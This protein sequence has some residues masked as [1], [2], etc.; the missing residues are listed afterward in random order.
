MYSVSNLQEF[1][2][3]HTSLPLSWSYHLNTFFFF[4]WLYMKAFSIYLE[5][6]FTYLCLTFVRGYNIVPNY[7]L[8]NIWLPVVRVWRK[9]ERQVNSCDFLCLIDDFHS[10][11]KAWKLFAY[12]RPFINLSKSKAGA[13]RESKWTFEIESNRLEMWKSQC[14]AK[15]LDRKA[16]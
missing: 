3:L 14:F 16:I 2:R 7:L 5:C 13:K 6:H 4:F 9:E 8:K 10:K 15:N 12:V 1:S 11:K